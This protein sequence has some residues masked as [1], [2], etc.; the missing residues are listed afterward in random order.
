MCFFYFF[1]T[2]SCKTY[3]FEAILGRVASQNALE[4]YDSVTDVPQK[5]GKASRDSLGGMR[6]S[7]NKAHVQALNTARVLR[8]KKADVMALN[9]AH[10]LRLNNK[11]C[12]V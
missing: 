3:T 9:K 12:P 11:I 5:V 10:V 1:R 4:Q 8:L 7:G 2:V 6:G